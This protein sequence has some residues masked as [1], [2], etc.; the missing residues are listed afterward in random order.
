LQR[1]VTA[2][3]Y[4]A[5]AARDFPA[6]LQGAAAGLIWTGS[7]YAARVNPDPVGREEAPPQLLE[8]ISV[9]LEK[10]RRMG[11]DLEVTPA[12][13]VPLTIVI[14]VCV[15]ADYQRAHVLAALREIFSVRKLA[16]GGAG[17][18]HPDNLRFGQ[19]VSLSRLTAAAQ[20]VAGVQWAQ[21]KTLERMGEGDQGEVENGYL[22]IQATEI[23][24]VDND[25][26]FPENGT[27]YFEMEGGR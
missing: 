10:Y 3:D 4:A 26:G 9:D 2:D 14:H 17:F 24:R 13:Y 27:I 18:F 5:L 25:P 12:R 8:R 11:H 20:A 21:V 7:W 16:S 1:A 19:G 23:V 22:P 6:D 15:K